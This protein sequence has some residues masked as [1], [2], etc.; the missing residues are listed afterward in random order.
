MKRIGPRAEPCGTTKE[1]SAGLE[2]NLNEVK[3]HDE[4]NIYKDF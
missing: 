4:A 1:T 2:Q 3:E